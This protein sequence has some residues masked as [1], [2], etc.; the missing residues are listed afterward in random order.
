MAVYSP[1]QGHW[2]LWIHEDCLFLQAANLEPAVLWR[3]MIKIG[4]HPNHK[5]FSPKIDTDRS[6]ETSGAHNQQNCTCIMLQKINSEIMQ[7][8]PSSSE[9]SDCVTSCE[10]A[11]FILYCVWDPIYLEKIICE[12]QQTWCTSCLHSLWESFHTAVQNRV[13]VCKEYHWCFQVRDH[14]HG[15]NWFR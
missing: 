7:P 3:Y 9:S 1:I 11:K 12:Q 2:Q 15:K 14:L 6:L 10:S 5:K 13:V 8:W 4:N